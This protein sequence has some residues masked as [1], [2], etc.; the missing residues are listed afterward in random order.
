M[1]I[2]PGESIVGFLRRSCR[3]KLSA[4]FKLGVQKKQ[5]TRWEPVDLHYVARAGDQFRIRP[6]DNNEADTHALAKTLIQVLKEKV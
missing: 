1:N 3:R 2:N 5:G 6:T 4:A